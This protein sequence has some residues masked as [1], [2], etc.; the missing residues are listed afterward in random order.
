M[1]NLDSEFVILCNIKGFPVALLQCDNNNI[2]SVG[3]W[4]DAVYSTYRDL[5][6]DTEIFYNLPDRLQRIWDEIT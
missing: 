2:I 4:T 1:I 3:E 5:I 6:G